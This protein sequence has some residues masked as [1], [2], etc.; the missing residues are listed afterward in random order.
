MKKQDYAVL[1]E[2]ANST[3]CTWELDLTKDEAN[4]RAEALA[5]HYGSHARVSVVPGFELSKLKSWST[6]S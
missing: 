6:Q 3:T 5:H 2:Y 4:A 1:I